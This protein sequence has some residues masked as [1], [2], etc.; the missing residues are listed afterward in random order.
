MSEPRENSALE[1][2]KYWR[3]KNS[4]PTENVGLYDKIASFYRTYLIRPTLNHFVCKHIADDSLLLHA[5]CG[6]GEVDTD[7]VGRMK[8][9]A[10]DISSEALQCYRS[11][12][13][14][15]ESIQQCSIMDMPFE[16]GTVD[17]VYNLGVMEHFSDAEIGQVLD[18]FHRVLTP[19]G[20]VVLLWP[21]VFGFSVIALH[22][23]HF[24]MKWIFRN[25]DRLHPDEPSKIKSRS[26]AFG[27][28]REAGFEPVEFGFGLR[29]FC[30]YAIIVGQKPS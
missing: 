21:P 26:H 27:L 15:V 14:S 29:D 25:P 10:V 13:P 8:I 30:T 4:G 2:D 3:G 17:G 28:L 11:N 24:V 22:I 9:A 1:W 6:S 20:K 19:G 16:V 23:I 18:E 5:G 7:L 12:H